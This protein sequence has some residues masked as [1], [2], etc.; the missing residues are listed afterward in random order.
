MFCQMRVCLQAPHRLGPGCQLHPSSTLDR[1]GMAPGPLPLAPIRG[2]GPTLRGQVLRAERMQGICLFRPLC[3]VT[4]VAGPMA[5]DVESLALCLRA[6]LSENMH[7]L[8]ATVPPLPFREEVYASSRRLRIGYYESDNLTQPSPSMTRAVRLTSKLLQD[9]GHQLIPFSVPRIEYAFIHLFTGGL[10]ADGGATLLEKLKG[11]I[12]DPSM[13]G[14][15]SQLCLPDPVKRFLAG[16]LRFTEPLTSQLL[17]ELRGVG[18]P[19]K[20]WEQH[21]AVEE[22]QQEFIAKWRSLDLDVLLAPALGPAFYIG[23]PAKAAR[24]S[25]YLALYNLLNFPAGVVPVTTVTPQD[26]E[27]LAFYRGYY[28]DGSDKNFQEVRCPLCLS[29]CWSG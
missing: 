2:L 25:F 12:V 24:S 4:T 17:E 10:Y 8:D 29:P 21:T 19:K 23:Y 16:I 14:L 22:Y 26:E 6:L 1:E 28:G 15:V 9:A 18:T 5:K 7:R 11:D 20:L 27:E 13:Q 3:A